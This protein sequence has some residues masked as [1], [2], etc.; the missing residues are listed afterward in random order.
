MIK[1]M[2]FILC[3]VFCLTSCNSVKNGSILLSFDHRINGEEITFNEMIYSNAAGNQYQIN[4]IKYFISKIYLI[5]SDGKEV[6]IANNENVH[7]TDLNYSE[8]LTWRLDGIEADD[9]SGISFIFGLDE[10]DNVDNRFVNPPETNFAWPTILGGGY[11]YMQINGKYKN[12]ENEVKSMNFHTG[13]G[14]LYTN[15]S[16]NT[17][18]IYQFVHNYFRV[19]VPCDFSVKKGA[20]TPLSLRMNIE[21]WFETPIIYDH[22]TFGGAIMQNQEAQLIIKNN[23]KDVF[24]LHP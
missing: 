4:E 8:T 24:T 21:S 10:E 22:N 2:C 15:N 13:I 7:Y 1:K 14:Q 12:S 5:N 17:E 19:T 6:C 16:T 23:G 18:D 3:G 11:H 20:E 9:Y